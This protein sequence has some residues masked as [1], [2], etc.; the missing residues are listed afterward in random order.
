MRKQAGRAVGA[1][2][3]RHRGPQPAAA[4]RGRKARTEFFAER[5]AVAV[6][7]LRAHRKSRH[8]LWHEG[9]A[10]FLVVGVAAG[11]QYH[12]F[13]RFDENVAPIEVYARASDAVAIADQL[14]DG[15][16][17]QDR[18]LTPAQAV[19]EPPNKR[20]AHHDAG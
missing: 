14:D 19:I 15:T 9:V 3:A 8:R 6:I 17:E 5:D 18:H 12:A 11:R 13:A 2:H 7:T 1:R 16:A 20:I 4:L 10:E